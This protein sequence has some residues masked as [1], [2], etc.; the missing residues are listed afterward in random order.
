LHRYTKLKEYYTVA[1]AKNVELSMSLQQTNDLLRQSQEQILSR[2]L[3][4]EQD[5]FDM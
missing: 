4:S 5:A 3:Y 1:D 2:Y